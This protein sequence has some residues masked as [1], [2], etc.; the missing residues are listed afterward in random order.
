[1][2]PYL[3]I[4]AVS[5]L[6]CAGWA[7]DAP[8]ETDRD[9]SLIVGFLEDNLSGAGRTIRIEGFKGF[10]SSAAT[11]DSLTISDDDGV[12]FTLNDAALDWKR[13]AL[14][15]GRLEIDHVSAAS[16][17]IL[18]RPQADTPQV[19]PEASVFSLPELPVSIN[20]GEI[21]ADMVTLGAEVLGIDQTVELSIDGAASLENGDGA[22]KLNI[23]RLSGPVGKFVLDTSYNNANAHFALDL[24]LNE[25]QGGF[26]S[27]LIGLPGAPDLS[28]TAKGAG[29]LDTFLADIELATLGQ[30][31]LSGTVGLSVVSDQNATPQDATPPDGDALQKPK[32]RAFFAD[33]SGDV[34]PL[35]DPAY[36]AFFGPSTALTAQGVSY[37]DG[38]MTLDAF[39]LGTDALVL[40]GALSMGADSLP[41]AFDISG[42]IANKTGAPSLLPLTGDKRYVQRVE[43][44]AQYDALRGEAWSFDALVS[45]YAQN[46]LSVDTISVSSTG[47]ISR[48]RDP[49][50]SGILR[51]LTAKIDLAASGLDI[52]D[53]ALK[54]AVGPDL[55]AQAQVSWRDGDPLIFKT[56]SAMAQDVTMAGTGTVSGLSS[57]FEFKGQLSLDAP[58]IS[59]FGPLA[60]RQIG[61]GI[62]ATAS[63]TFAPLGGMFDAQI[64]GRAQNARLG[65]PKVDALLAGQSRFEIRARRDEAGLAIE[66]FDVKTPALAAQGSGTLASETAALALD[67]KLDDLARLNAGIS[68][69]LTAAAQI[70]K[71]SQNGPWQTNATLVGPGGS[72]ARLA[73]SIAQ[74]LDAA[75]LDIIGT[76]PLGL[77]NKLTTA[78]LLQG[79]ADFDLRLDGPL[80]LS[81]M[82][83]VVSTRAGARAVLPSAGLTL[84][85]DQFRANL[86]NESATLEASARAD[87]G[88]RMTASG[89][90]GLTSDLLA[91]LQLILKD[92][93]IGD[94]DLFNT[95]VGGKINV[96]GPIAAGPRVSGALSL[97]RTDVRVAPVALGAGGDIPEITHTSEPLA[98]RQT[99]TRAGVLSAGSSTES[100]GDIAIDIAITAPNQVFIR[101]RGL[102]AELGGTLRLTGTTS[103]IIPIG[104][105]SLI[106]GRLSL[107]GK[108]IEMEDGLLVLQGDFDPSFSLVAATTTDDLTVRITTSGRVSSPKIELS[109]S[110]DLPE[111]EI[112]AQLLFGRALSDISAFQAAQMAAAVAT[113]TGGGGGIVGSIRD[114]IGLDDLDVTTSNEGETALRVGKYL[115]DEIYT[116][117]T[118][119]STGK[120]IINLNL[121]AS[122]TVTLKGS[123]SPDGATS[124]GVFFE[125]DY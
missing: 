52:A 58:N 60:G 101:G 91:D 117:V 28:L 119:D 11:M 100:G 10:L 24:S 81:S 53:A 82:T 47:A 19:A 41:T 103:N 112:L 62:G 88:G 61:G 118:I 54:A 59:R 49:Q 46:D 12:W 71:A 114:T 45:D 123:M 115:S 3:G 1:M 5:F 116:D 87:T 38:R 21:T 33:I 85:F 70:S 94:P 122:D 66:T 89:R 63:G 98:V 72:T 86:A 7:Q 90:V 57:G 22:A 16:I 78:T 31:R 102:D 83:G 25:G 79:M 77:A 2:K 13:S 111:D 34:T 99:R 37:P 18:R 9:R 80:A 96:S 67:V 76:V 8:A 95:S 73:G 17:N 44:S 93:V 104:Q 35:F 65:I 32:A 106:R 107:L 6:P 105:F 56:F 84:T 15:S 4:L 109:S 14:L 75:A 48:R 92:I 29:P 64:S 20:I 74:S 40:K 69:P 27:T 110:P 42:V 113:L 108:R 36:A 121:D 26:I 120:S 43:L 51:A 30:P 23:Q 68:G 124:L 50:N 125:K 39:S 55:S 97:G